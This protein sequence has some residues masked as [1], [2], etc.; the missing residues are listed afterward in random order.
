M[1]KV[2]LVACLLTACGFRNGTPFDQQLRDGALVI[3]AR[4][5]APGVS[6]DAYRAAPTIYAVDADNL[7]ALDI[8]GQQ[9]TT[10][11]PLHDKREDGA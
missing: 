9:A 8:A 3:D 5:D 1:G 2:H 4:P 11:G 6:V 7:Y 10:I